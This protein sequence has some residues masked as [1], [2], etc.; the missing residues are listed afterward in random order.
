MIAHECG[1]RAFSDHIWLGD[2]VGLVLHSALMVPYHPWRISHAKHHRSTNDMDRDEA[3][4]HGVSATITRRR[5]LC[6]TRAVRW[7]TC[8]ACLTDPRVCLALSRC[9]FL[10]RLHCLCPLP[11]TAAGWPAYLL[12]NTAGRKYGARTSHYE[13]RSPLFLPQ[14]YWAVVISDLALVAVAATLVQLT[15]I[16]G[17]VWLVKVRCKC[18][19]GA[20]IERAR[21]MWCSSPICNT[22]T[23]RC[24]TTAARTGRG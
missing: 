14:Q 9:C 5:C 22:R 13:P 17:L 10:V 7:A 8:P 12:F 6:R 24:R 23:R 4:K 11:L 3:R 2:V 15:A 16:F 1:H 19:A 20:W 18:A 21:C